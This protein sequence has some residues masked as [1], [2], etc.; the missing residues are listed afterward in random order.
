MLDFYEDHYR[1]ILE[2][3]PSYHRPGEALEVFREIETCLNS[4][5]PYILQ[6]DLFEI[7]EKNINLIR[8]AMEA[9]ATH[10]SKSFDHLNIIV[11]QTSIQVSHQH[12]K[13]GYPP[14]TIFLQN[15]WQFPEFL[16]PLTL[17][18][19][20]EVLTFKFRYVLGVAGMEALSKDLR[21]CLV[22]SDLERLCPK[23]Q[24]IRFWC[25]G[26]RGEQKLFHHRPQWHP[27]RG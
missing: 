2:L 3:L 26:S 21:S 16:K 7:S 25:Q 22:D 19:H 4:S 6:L 14:F 23:L 12:L 27:V 9:V 15:L 17:F 13:E 24:Y 11:N 5:H 1:T 10:R 8:E 20:L 18:R